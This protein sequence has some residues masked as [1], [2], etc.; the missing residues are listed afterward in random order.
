MWNGRT[1]AFL[2]EIRPYAVYALQSAALA[3]V[4]LM[5]GAGIGYHYLLTSPPPSFPFRLLAACILFPAAALSPIR[6]YMKEAD[7]IFLMPM[8]SR[9]S[10]Y[11]AKASRRSFSLQM[12]ALLVAWLAAWPLYA[13]AAGEHNFLL[14]IHILLVL[15]VI[16]RIMVYG[17]NLE[18]RLTEK[19]IIFLYVALRTL[20]AA[21]TVYLLTALQIWQ[22]TL[23][24][25]LLLLVYLACL[26]PVRRTPA[27]W[28][29]LVELEKRHRGVTF[30]LLNNFIDVPTV[31]GRP[32]SVHAPG[33][34]L[35]AIGGF[36]HQPNDTYRFL[37][38]LVWLRSEWFGVTVRLTL[39]GVLLLALI[40][41]AL[42]TSIV[43]ALFAGLTALQLKELQKAYRHSD[44]SFIYP[45]PPA[46]RSR[47]AARVVL[48]IHALCLAALAIPSLWSM[49]SPLHAAAWFAGTLL[50]SYFYSRRK[51]S[52]R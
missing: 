34:L 35:A 41:G 15:V 8:E 1:A 30:R 26:Y 38:T 28:P 14:F 31:Q 29:R 27:N 48:R 6:T 45:L 16:K 11:F 19:R 12:A 9:M 32:R 46:L 20:I 44:W 22:G 7:L 24:A 21:G 52:G 18:I 43:Y 42:A 39:L 5:L 10:A 4:L 40:S 51:S 33:K 50:L 2:A 17:R 49:P 25:G 23:G 13:K 47:S 37:Y 36:R 3:I